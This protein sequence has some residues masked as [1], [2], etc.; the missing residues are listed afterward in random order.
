MGALG[1]S[2]T[3]TKLK[4]AAND[5]PYTTQVALGLFG[6]CTAQASK[7]AH[8]L[9]HGLFFPF[10]LNGFCFVL[11]L[12]G[13]AASTELPVTRT[14]SAAPADAACT[15]VKEVS[16][17]TPSPAWP[18]TNRPLLMTLPRPL[19]P[20]ERT[21][22]DESVWT[23]RTAWLFIIYILCHGAVPSTKKNVLFTCS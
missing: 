17:A 22:E 2:G 20:S 18:L 21:G 4:S 5:L 14:T 13:S 7:V 8:W 12:L 11:F 3:L 9:V 10:F 23:A 16:M 19:P 15:C 1:I 6:Q